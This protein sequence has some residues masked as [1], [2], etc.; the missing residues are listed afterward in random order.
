MHE[1]ICYP[2][3]FPQEICLMELI[4]FEETQAFLA[5]E[6][7]LSDCICILPSWLGLGKYEPSKE[8][9]PMGPLMWSRA[10]FHLL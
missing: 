4:F 1:L 2:V 3:L 7:D 5:R 8:Q 9:L 6:G 10:V